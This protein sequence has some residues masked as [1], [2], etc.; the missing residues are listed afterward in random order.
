MDTGVYTEHLDFEGRAEHSANM[1]KN[2]DDID[3]GGHGN[4]IS[5]K[6]K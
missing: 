6:K 5:K 2:E 4:V 1:I 3:M